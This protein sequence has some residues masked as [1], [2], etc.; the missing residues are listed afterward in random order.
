MPTTYA[1]IQD[2][3][4]FLRIT[5]DG[6]TSPNT[7]QVEKLIN[8][9]EERIDRRTGHTFGRSRTET[10]IYPLHLLYTFGHG[11]PFTLKHRE[12]KTN[13]S[14][15]HLCSCAGDKLEVWNGASGD[16]SNVTDCDGAY[17]VEPI[18]GDIYM[19]GFIFTIIRMDRIRI[20]Y[21]YG[22]TT[23]PDDIREACIKLVCVDIIKSSLRMDDIQFGG[24][25]DKE[26]AMDDWID[27]VDKIIRDREEVYILP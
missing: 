25:I 5:I 17:D 6:S 18:K 15:I 12:I 22:S 11:A 26:K 9:K 20:T 24:A 23:V 21:R 7:A 3:A 14:G 19:R 10:E 4:D 16:Y 27:D 2:V 13:N 8:Y 1:S